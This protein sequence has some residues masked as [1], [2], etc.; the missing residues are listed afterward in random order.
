MNILTKVILVTILGLLTLTAFGQTNVSGT[1][2]DEVDQTK[3]TNATV[4]LLQ[5]KDSIL[6]DFIRAD[7]DGRFKLQSPDTADYLLI[8]SYP[9]FGDFYQKIA[10]GSGDQALGEVQ[11]QSAANL[12]EEVLVTGKIPVVIK[13]DTVEYDAGSFVT[14]KNAKVEDLLKV[15]PGMSVDANGAITAQGKTVEKVLVD[16]EEFFGDDPTLVTRNIRSDMVDKVQVYEK[17][18]EESERTGVDDGE[19][20]Q[21][22]NVQLKEDAK[23]GVFGKIEGAGGLDDN[24]GYYLGKLAVNKFSGSQKIGAYLLTSNDGNVSLN[25]QEEEKFNL[26]DDQMEVTESGGVNFSWGGDEFSYWDGKGQPIALSTGI[27]FMDAW[28]EKKHKLNLSYKYANIKNDITENNIN[29]TPSDNGLINNDMNSNNS[30]DAF[31]HRFNSKYDLDIDSLTTLTMKLS[32]SRSQS[33]RNSHIDGQTFQGDSLASENFSD[34]Y[35]K[36]INSNLTYDGYLTRKFKKEGR[37][38]SLRVAGNLSE[39]EGDMKINSEANYF[40]LGRVDTIDQMKD[41]SSSTNNFRSS[42]TYTE[43]LGKYFKTSI[44]Y[45][46]NMS[47]SNSINNSF[48]KDQS[49]A[50]TE[51][52]ELYSN[53]FDFNTTRNAAN[54]T[55]GY[56]TEKVEVNFTN[57]FRIDDMAQTNNYER[58]DLNREYFTYNP[59]AW[60]RYSFSKNKR[61]GV[62]YDR[63]NQLPGLFQIQPLRQNTDQMNQILGNENLKPANSNKFSVYYNSYDMLKGKYIYGNVSLTQN[64]SAIQQNVTIFPGGRREMYYDNADQ[65]GYNGSAWM[66]GGFDLVRKHQIKADLGLQANLNTYSNYIKDLTLENAEADFQANDNTSYSYNLRIGAYKNTTK[67]IDFNVNFRPG[68]TVLKTTLNPDLN[69]DGFTFNSNVWFKYYLPAKFS[70]YADLSYEYQAPTNAFPDKFERVLFKPGI[71]R[72]FLKG[73]NLVVDFYVNDLLKQNTGFR[74]FQSGNAITQTSYNTISR[75]FMLKVSWDFTSMKGGE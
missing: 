16:G 68:W 7:Q 51:L 63:N 61:I 56:K 24:S 12:I 55:L 45:E 6:V 37:S 26:S 28:K 50:Y 58:T 54:L 5:A 41:M 36:S 4:M 14:E 69:S 39:D 64:N 33:E 47:K 2:V 20:I 9:K 22:I 17:K 31:R 38:I 74:R 18:S 3:L 43:P 23:K 62:N 46:Y 34:Q 65:A 27:S 48:N 70:L 73:E 72:K 13:G 1:V 29:Q 8:I 60:F 32:G 59:S 75:Y 25:W 42:I 71:S 30:S 21:T 11:L 44:G 49:G 53:D 35:S 40:S 19:R 66:G 15:L 10:Q 57:N 52:D 67:N